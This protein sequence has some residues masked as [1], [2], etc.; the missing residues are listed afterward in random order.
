MI[1]EHGIQGESL[2]NLFQYRNMPLQN[3]QL[4]KFY[5][6]FLLFKI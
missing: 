3:Q 4:M 5:N 6:F 1:H 2:L